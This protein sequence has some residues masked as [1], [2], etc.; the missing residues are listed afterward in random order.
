MKLHDDRK[1]INRQILLSLLILIFSIFGI[2]ILALNINSPNDSNYYGSTTEESFKAIGI[3]L[4]T[5]IVLCMGFF[6]YTGVQQKNNHEYMY[7]NLNFASIL[8]VPAIFNLMVSCYE[9]SLSDF[10]NYIKSWF[11]PTNLTMFN[12]DFQKGQTTRII[13]FIFWLFDLQW[14]AILLVD[15]FGATGGKGA[16][17]DSFH[18]FTV[19]ANVMVFFYLWAKWLMP[20]WKLF[21]SNTLLI[22][23]I[24][25]IVIVALGYN[26]VLLPDSISKG[27]T[28]SWSST[29]WYLEIL[30]HM[31]I[32]LLFLIYGI[33][34]FHLSIYTRE[35]KLMKSIGYG[36][37]YPTMY[38]I[39]ALFLPFV[40]DISVYGKFSNINIANGGDYT[41]YG[42]MFG[43]WILF[44]IFIALFWS[45]NHLAVHRA[46]QGYSDRNKE[47]R[48]NKY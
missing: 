13:T 22:L 10:T 44:I 21:N 32:P 24:S 42:F 47:I 30:Q 26:A 46:Q 25:Y 18:F 23:I 5:Y 3:V 40:S 33:Y 28:N 4:A 37:V 11:E 2:I 31:I 41:S 1:L 36:I 12:P 48:A 19:Q 39:Y 29:D 14:I 45:L 20:S 27:D 9:S 8:I 15:L 34:I 7:S 38:L 17:L 6:A 43:F 35:L 16:W